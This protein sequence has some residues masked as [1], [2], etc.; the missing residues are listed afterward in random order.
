MAV[1]GKAASDFGSRMRHVRE[2]MGV[3]L[4][5]IAETTKLSVSALVRSWKAVSLVITGS[6]SGVTR[7]AIAVEKRFSGE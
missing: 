3:S 4:R 2:Q 1:A 6:A 7:W 5:Q